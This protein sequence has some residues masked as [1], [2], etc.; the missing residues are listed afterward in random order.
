MKDS[1]NQKGI[2]GIDAGG[3]FTD[4]VFITGNESNVAAYVKIPTRHENILKTIEDGLCAIM[5]QIHI[6]DITTINL[7]TTFATNAIVENKL[8][9][10]GLVL[11]GYDP[12]VVAKAIDDN[13]F[14]TDYVIQ[15]AGGHDP[16][17]DE[18]EPLDTDML[19]NKVKNILPCLESVAISSFFSVRNPSHEIQA[20]KLIHSL[21]PELHVTCGHEL[22]SE[23]DAIKR[24]VTAVINAGLIPLM[25][26][27]F[28]SVEQVLKKRG[29]GA[30]VFVV[31]GDGSL[32]SA[33]WAK[34]H[35]IET[36]LS[37]PAASAIGACHLAGVKNNN[38]RSAWVIDMGGTTTDIIHI[39]EH[40]R[41]AIN[42]GGT[43]V[44]GHRT[45]IKSIDIKTFGLGG[46]SRVRFGSHGVLQLGPRRVKPLCS[47]SSE[48][49]SIMGCIEKLSHNRNCEEPVVITHSYPARF[50]DNFEASVIKRLSH[51]ASTFPS[52]LSDERLVHAGAAK[53]EKMESKGLL[54]FSG[55]TPTDALHVLGKLDIWDKRASLLGAEI[56]AKNTNLTVK[57]VSEK[58]CCKAAHDIVLNILKKG[59]S[60]TGREITAEKESILSLALC[61][62][63]HGAPGLSA[64]INAAIIGAGAPAWAFIH[65]VAQ[66]LGEKAILPEHADVAGAVG[67][68]VGTFALRYAVLISPMKDNIY[69]VHLPEGTLDFD[70]I[71]SAV[72]YSR[73][74]LTPWITERA[75]SSGAVKPV[76]KFSREDMI[77]SASAGREVHLWTQLWFDVAD[78]N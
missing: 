2:L 30:P 59:F 73:E 26:D 51:G 71:D 48:N 66:L 72:E 39:N 1:A 76:I 24:A 56:L 18:L 64:N 13:I 38:A 20:K 61:A 43:T 42:A 70:S 22:A 37:G 74:F 6:Q 21:A 17:G 12:V 31:R 25:I 49:P 34:L 52:L 63:E 77:V 8:R 46:D 45:L 9:P 7:A 78:D 35:P 36:I 55:F 29:C 50:T 23:L 5:K 65:D 11:I 40:G 4:L 10:A 41:P 19:V 57:Q 44:G 60:R 27:L 69:R 3:T 54:A 53:L 68:A 67:A 62:P 33:E 32:V 15:V 16:K 14:N 28:S 47:A 58:V 75:K